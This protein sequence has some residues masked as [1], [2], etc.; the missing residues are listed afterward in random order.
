MNPTTN[1]QN[2]SFEPSPFKGDRGVLP[3]GEVFIEERNNTWNTPFLFN[4]K[5]LDE[6]TGLYYYGARYY[7]ARIGL[8]YGVDPLNE[9]RYGLS[10]YQYCQNSPV[11]LTD[12]TGALDGEYELD[13]NNNWQKVST[14]GDDIGVDFYHWDKKDGSQTTYVTDRQGNWNTI[15]NGRYALQGTSRDNS[16]GWSEIYNEFIDGTGPEKSVF[17]GN[18]HPSNQAIKDNYLYKGAKED[19]TKSGLSKDGG[20]VN[21]WYLW[22]NV[23]TGTNMQVQMMGS[24]NASFY[25]LGNKT[26]SLI[27]D[28]KSRTSYYYHLPVMNYPRSQTRYVTIPGGYGAPMLR[29]PHKMESTT[30]QTYFFLD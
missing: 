25:K 28:S 23:R 5:E 7:N 15:N 13:S 2:L 11:M 30:Y 26:L 17:E 19:F 29:I 27:Q 16:A 22:D 18:A 12:P 10:P 24:Y 14:K 3:F 1:T 8:W 20:E 21:F 6:E 4:G 9:E